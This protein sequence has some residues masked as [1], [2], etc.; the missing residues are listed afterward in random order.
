MNNA[1]IWLVVKPTVGIPV[2]LGAVAVAGFATHVAVLSYTSWY[3]DYLQGQPLGTTAAAATAEAALVAPEA[4][5]A[6]Y[7]ATL[8]GEL[9]VDVLASASV[10]PPLV[11]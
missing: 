3:N 1:K 11:E 9:P 2:F 6:S 5:S 10:A 4:E 8:D 7:A